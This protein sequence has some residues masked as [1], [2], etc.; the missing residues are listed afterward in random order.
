LARRHRPAL[1]P[2]EQEIG[3]ASAGRDQGL[4]HRACYAINL[5]RECG[6]RLKPP[7]IELFRRSYDRILKEGFAFHEAQ[8]SLVRAPAPGERKRRGRQ[9]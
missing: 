7:L 2:L 5:A 1:K 8:L 3:N 6:V 9:R 4:L